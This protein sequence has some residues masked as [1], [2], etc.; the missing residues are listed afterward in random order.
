MRIRASG[1]VCLL[2]E[3]R[4]TALASY[5]D[6]PLILRRVI[7]HLRDQEWTAISI[8]FIIVVVG[9]VVGIQVSNWNSD[10]Q[11]QRRGQV[12]SAK[13]TQDLGIEAW[14]YQFLIEYN[15]DVLHNAERAIEYLSGDSDISDEQFLINA[16]RAT[17]YSYSDRARE[18][19]DELISTGEIG[20]I[21][22]SILR[23][24]ASSIYNTPMFD[25]I[26]DTGKDSEFRRIFRGNVPT[27]IQRVLLNECGE[28]TVD[29]GDYDA[30]VDALDYKCSLGI[31]ESVIK[32]AASTLRANVATLPALRVRLADAETA[33]DLLTQSQP[34]YNNLRE[35]GGFPRRGN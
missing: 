13:L 21:S 28:I 17:R 23:E 8:D 19:Y 29:T 11:A 32:E 16:Y 3:K 9:V 2:P 15:D 22:E 7:K 1:D 34:L 10:L 4:G 25:L 20:L 24:T 12:F 5:G 33:L 6:F 30:I 27:Q 26:T 14:S 18:T 31:S 35:I